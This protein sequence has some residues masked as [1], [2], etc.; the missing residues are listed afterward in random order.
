MTAEKETPPA[1]LSDPE[2]MGGWP[3]FPGTRVPAKNLFDY[4]S[5]G[6]SLE[7][8]LDDFPTVTRDQAIA[9]L[10]LALKL[11]EDHAYSA[12]RVYSEEAQGH[13]AGIR[14]LGSPGKTLER[15]AERGAA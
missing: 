7:V 14:S 13:D 12:R 4:L 11:V 8:F 10:D 2:I 3:A 6:D 1:V 9:M 5:G 15:E